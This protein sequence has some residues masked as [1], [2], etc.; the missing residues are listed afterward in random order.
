MPSIKHLLYIDAPRIDVFHKLTTVEG[1]QKWW[2]RHIDGDPDP[3]S[4]MIFHFG[5]N[6]HFKM[7][8]AEMWP[9]RAVSWM[10]KGGIMSWLGTKISYKLDDHHG[11][12]R[13]RFEHVNWREADD[14]Y[15]A[16]TFTWARYLESLR[17][18]CETGSG[19]PYGGADVEEK[20]GMR[21]V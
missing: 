11:K 1:L 15:A 10:C 21:V 2:T 8:V 13:L 5:P 12:T 19:A 3:G 17:K 7:E 18:Y 4:E 6:H 14:F 16:C 20:S 9:D